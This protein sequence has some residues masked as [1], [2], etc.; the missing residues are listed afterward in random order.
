MSYEIDPNQNLQ[1]ASL[2]SQLYWEPQSIFYK[3]ELFKDIA[4]NEVNSV[5]ALQKGNGALPIREYLPL[6]EDSNYG[7]YS[8]CMLYHLSQM[9]GELKWMESTI[10]I[11]E[12]LHRD[13]SVEHPW[14]TPDDG[15]NFSS[16]RNYNPY[17]L[18][19]RI[20]P[21]YAAGISKDEISEWVDFIKATFPDSELNLDTRWYF[22]QSIP[23]SYLTNA[24]FS[25]QLIPFIFND[26]IVNNMLSIRIVGEKIDEVELI[27]K[28]GGGKMV[29]HEKN[30]KDMTFSKTVELQNGKIS[31]KVIVKGNGQKINSMDGSFY[32]DVP[33]VVCFNSIIFDSNN[34][35]L[36]RLSN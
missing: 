31:Y 11:G 16:A 20:L 9:W 3:K 7:G 17:N 23:R 6:V 1:V 36:K 8:G 18:I 15:D 14:N 27:V 24:Q 29:F 34:T 26:D 25:N 12:W 13:F 33:K 32:L 2:F 10:M 30:N 5:I 22:Y 21:F 35:F 19:G 4:Y 28:D